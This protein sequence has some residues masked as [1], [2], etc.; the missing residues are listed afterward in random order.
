MS[1][2]PPLEPGRGRTSF[3]VPD[4]VPNR[5]RT[6]QLTPDER[7]AGHVHVWLYDPD[8]ELVVDQELDVDGDGVLELPIPDDPA[9]GRWTLDRGVLLRSMTLLPL[10]PRP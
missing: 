2:L 4:D 6:A 9:P 7:V 1:A 10:G 3:V 5:Y 8:G